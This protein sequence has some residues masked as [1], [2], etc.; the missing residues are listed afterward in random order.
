MNIQSL[1]RSLIGDMPRFGS[2]KLPRFANPSQPYS[3]RELIAFESKLGAQLFGPVPT[4]HQREFFCVDETSWI[5]YDAWRENGE[6]RQTTIR[7]EVQPAGVL[8]IQ[9]GA[10]YSYL[11]GAELQNFIKAVEAY[12]HAVLTKLYHKQVATT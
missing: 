7:Y 1:V 9:Q 5:W 4:G 10:R 2:V 6:P 3:E 11:E 12:H 8:K